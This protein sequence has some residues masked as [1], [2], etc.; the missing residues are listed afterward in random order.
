MKGPRTRL[1]RKLFLATKRVE[2]R[3]R[4]KAADEATKH[5]RLDP[6]KPID[7]KSCEDP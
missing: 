3:I 5:L 2:L 1:S 7:V 4:Q 6:D